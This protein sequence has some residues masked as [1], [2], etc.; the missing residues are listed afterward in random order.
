M[1]EDITMQAVLYLLGGMLIGPLVGGL[2]GWWKGFALGV[3]AGCLIIGACGLYGA[4]TLGHSRYHALAGTEKVE[5]V[6]LRWTSERTTDSDGDTTTVYAPVVRFNA[7]DGRTY[8]V[9]GLGRSDTKIAPG[10]PVPVRYRPEDPGQALIADFQ[11]LWGGVWGLGLFGIV[12]TMMGAFFAGMAI[13]DARSA[14]R[15]GLPKRPAAPEPLP[16]WRE[17][18][19]KMLSRAAGPLL[20]L[21]FAATA[22]G[23]LLFDD[24]FMLL[25]GSGFLAVSLACCLWLASS[26][27]D[28]RLG[29]EGNM[30]FAIIATGFALFGFAAVMMN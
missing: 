26:V 8:E 24:A 7:L 17:Q 19:A 15:G 5:G 2:L 27:L 25:L 30:I 11:N 3:G 13:R 4:T 10:D 20:L 1:N 28:R 16:P 12:P 22:L 18:A 29:W 23:V 14:G 21:A 6:L 9:K